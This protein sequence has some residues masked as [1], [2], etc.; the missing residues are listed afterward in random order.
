ME[1]HFNL[2]VLLLSIEEVK[3][4]QFHCCMYRVDCIFLFSGGLTKM[5]SFYTLISVLV[6]PNFCSYFV[7]N[8]VLVCAPIPIDT[9]VNGKIKNANFG[10]TD[11]HYCWKWPERV[12]S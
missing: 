7:P 11:E 3:K 2:F 1:V 4:L 5:Q 12:R 9:Y 8:F 10:E 6:L